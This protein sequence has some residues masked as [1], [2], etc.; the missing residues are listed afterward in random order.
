MANP[1]NITQYLEV[2]YVDSLDY[3]SQSLFPSE[4]IYLELHFKLVEAYIKSLQNQLSD[5]RYKDYEQVL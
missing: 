3:V 1:Q 5:L 4:D 2:N